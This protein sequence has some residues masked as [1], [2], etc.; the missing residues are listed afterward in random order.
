MTKKMIIWDR[1]RVD[2]LNSYH[3]TIMLGDGRTDWKHKLTANPGSIRDS[4]DGAMIS[5]AY[6]NS[7]LI[8][9]AKTD[10]ELANLLTKTDSEK[11]KVFYAQTLMDH[12]EED[13]AIRK[14]A[15]KVLTEDE[16]E[17]DS[18]G[19]PMLSDIVDRLVKKIQNL[20]ISIDSLIND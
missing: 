8:R 14:E 3:A 13:T 4:I 16:V 10:E 20:E 15:R 18:Y 6:S 2:W 7:R 5:D 19:V 11:A 17:G 12:A 1:E 9:E